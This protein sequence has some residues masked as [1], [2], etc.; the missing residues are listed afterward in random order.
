MSYI[1][2]AIAVVLLAF[3]FAC[4][5]KYQALEG[6]QMVPGLR[7]NALTGLLSALTMLVISGFQ[8]AWSPL[9]LILAIGQAACCIAYSLIGFRVLKMGGMALYST[10]LMSGGMLLPYFVG[11]AFWNE[12]LSWLRIVGVVLILG[13]VILSNFTRE[14]ISKK[15]IA[16][17]CTV[18]VLNGF[19]SILSK[20]HQIKAPVDSTNFAMYAGAAKFLLCSLVLIFCRKAP[21]QFMQ[22]RKSYLVIAVTAVVCGVSYL[23]QLMGAKDLPATVLYPMITGG[24]VVM[25]ALAGMVFF[26]EKISKMQLISILLCLAGTLFFL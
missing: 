2:V 9:S 21:S 25:S 26:K 1:Y 3:E 11:V 24:C 5:K 10:F 8:P 17:C 15:L 4:S 18:F 7:F 20:Y 22:N 19:V 16:L 23:L 6:A 12:Q 14:K 13:A